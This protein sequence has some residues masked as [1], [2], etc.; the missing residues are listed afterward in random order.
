MPVRRGWASRGGDVSAV[1]ARRFDETAGICMCTVVKN[2]D[3]GGFHVKK[4]LQKGMD[5]WYNR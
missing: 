1:K 3:L 5:V 4:Y 2:D